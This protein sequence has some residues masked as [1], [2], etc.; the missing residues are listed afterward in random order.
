MIMIG[1]FQSLIT[2]LL[3]VKN[4]KTSRTFMLLSRGYTNVSIF[5]KNSPNTKS[6]KNDN[7]W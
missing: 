3:A 7:D 2:M 1:S 5:L 4:N 6:S